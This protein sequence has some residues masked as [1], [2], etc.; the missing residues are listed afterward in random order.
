MTKAKES[1]GNG[2]QRGAARR[3]NSVSAAVEA[4]LGIDHVKMKMAADT[5]AS[6][7]STLRVFSRHVKKSREKEEEMMRKL[8]GEVKKSVDALVGTT[9]KLDRELRNV[10]AYAR[11]RLGVAEDH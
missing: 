7:Q 4:A 9:Q 8:R 1:S 3:K 11:L 5:L 6:T 2:K 10:L